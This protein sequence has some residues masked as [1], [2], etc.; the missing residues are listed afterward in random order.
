M[1]PKLRKKLYVHKS[2]ACLCGIKA[3]GVCAMKATVDR[4]EGSYAIVMMRDDELVQFPLPLSLM[5]NLAEGDILEI[6]I[7]KDF[8][9]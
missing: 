3:P 5:P 2:D 9:G 1:R 7:R 4:I 6:D 8:S